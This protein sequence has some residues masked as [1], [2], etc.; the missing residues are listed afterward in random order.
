[1][2]WQIEFTESAEKQLLKLP[3]AVRTR[4]LDVL[5]QRIAS[6]EEGPRSYG[7]PLKGQLKGLWRFRVGEY[8]VLCQLLDEELVILVVE[9]VARKDAY[10]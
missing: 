9:V 3:Q 5:E 1:M 7:K 8:R 10:P 6:A 2:A 4:I